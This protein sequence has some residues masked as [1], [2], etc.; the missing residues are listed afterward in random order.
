MLS[1]LNRADKGWKKLC[2][3]TEGSLKVWVIYG[4]S[5]EGTRGCGSQFRQR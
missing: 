4:K 1:K 5:V 2:M 3:Q